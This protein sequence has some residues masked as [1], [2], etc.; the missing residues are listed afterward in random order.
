MDIMS[1]QASSGS[2][3]ALRWVSVCVFQS[4]LHLLKAWMLPGRGLGS[5]DPQ[6]VPY[7][8]W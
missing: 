1:A 2:T 6:A 7:E 3:S 5:L 4:L 8:I